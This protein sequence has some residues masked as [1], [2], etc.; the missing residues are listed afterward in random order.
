MPVTTRK[1]LAITFLSLLIALPL[2]AQNKTT[3]SING[4]VKDNTDAVLPGVT[5]TVV[6]TGTGLTRTAYT[7]ASG[8]YSVELLPPGAYKVSAVLEGLGTAERDNVRVVLGTSTRVPLVIAPQVS[9]VIVVT[10]DAPLVDTKQSG[11]TAVVSEEQIANLPILGRDFKDLVL[12]TPGVSETFG[13]RVSL[14]GGRGITTDYNID[15]AEANSDFFG[16]ERGGTEAPFVFSQAAIREFQVIRTSYSAEYSRSAG[17]TV[18]AITKSGTNQIQG[19]LFWYRRDAGWADERNTED[20]SEF[21]EARDVDQFGFAA[22]GPI[23][24][25]K[26]HY[27]VNGDFQRISEPVNVFDWRTDRDFLE[28]DP[29]VQQAVINKIEGLLGNSIDDELAYTS[30]QD[31]DT[32]LVKFDANLTN[33]HHMSVRWNY[34]DYNNFPS[35]SPRMLSNQGDEYNTSNSVVAQMESVLSANL[36]NQAIIQYALE[37]RPINALNNTVPETTISGGG[38]FVRFGQSEFLPNRTDEEKFQIKDNISWISGNHTVKGG[39]EYLST[40]IDNLFPREYAGQ[41][42]F[43]SVDRFL[44]DRPNNLDQGYGPTGGLNAYDLKGWGVYIQDTWTPNPNLTVDFGL[45]YDVQDIPTPSRNEYPQR[46]EFVDWFNNDTDNFAPRFGV[47]YDLKGDGRSVIRGGIGRFFSPLPSILYA[48][49]TAE[50]SGLYTRIRAFCPSQ[51]PGYPGILAPDDFYELARTA[52][53]ITVV[54]PDLEQQEQVRTS[55][56]YEQMLGDSYS[57]SIEGVYS[58]LSKQ[59]RL[60]NINAVPTGLVFGNMPVYDIGSDDRPYDDFQQVRMHVS[61]AEGTY[62]SITLSTK[63]LAVGDSRFSWLAHYTW[64]ESQVQDSNERSTSTSFSLDPFD[65]SVGEGRA[66]YD[67]THRVVMSGTYELPWGFFVS[68][69][70]NWNSG[71]PYTAGIEMDGFEMLNGIDRAGIDVPVFIDSN[72][73]IVDMTL[74]TGMNAEELSAF[75]SGARLQ[76]RNSYDQPSFLNIDLRIAK[77]F[78]IVDRYTL[79]IIGEVFNLTNEKNKYTGE[80]TMFFGDLE[81]DGTYTFT[82]NQDFGEITSFRGNPRQYQLALKFIF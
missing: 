56:A 38:I 10:A 46:P 43:S 57:V 59:Q 12:L 72:G 71:A 33:N 61:D 42:F 70:L 67:I 19:E 26:Y 34:A 25:D 75:L 27:F 7:E 21:F 60:V 28:L 40:S 2:A 50:I 1:I 22:G 37:E 41:Y 63:K 15:G 6:N 68:G 44:E 80:Q 23:V 11:L 62:K 4:V 77:R 9:E 66:D 81:R 54:S 49:P 24:R 20:V 3:G 47:A 36:F 45:R 74:A 30:K 8:A 14:N 51:C 17:G 58:D 29:A 13:D 48:G 82:R 79:E 39:F 53:L 16:E 32:Y 73:A 65:P 52:S 69:I 18:N 64:S 31:Q 35:E 76:E 78:N 5:V 55:L